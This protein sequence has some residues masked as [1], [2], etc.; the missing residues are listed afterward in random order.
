MNVEG[1]TENIWLRN[2]LGEAL[3][4]LHGAGLFMRDMRYSRAE[5]TLN[6]VKD[7]QAKLGGPVAEGDESK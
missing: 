6:F 2:L 1:L 4:R 3:Q 7:T 5:D